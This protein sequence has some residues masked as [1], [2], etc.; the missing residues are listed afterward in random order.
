MADVVQWHSR[1]AAACVVVLLYVKKTEGAGKIE[2]FGRNRISV[3][4]PPQHACFSCL[5]TLQT[6]RPTDLDNS[7]LPR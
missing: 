5:Y 6:K 7:E 1:R 3:E 4:N 2:R